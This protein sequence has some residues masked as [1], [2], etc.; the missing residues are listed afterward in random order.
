MTR[1]KNILV[2]EFGFASGKTRE[3]VL[4]KREHIEFCKTWLIENAEK[5]NVASDDCINSYGLKH[6]IESSVGAYITNGACIQAA[7]DLG[8]RYWRDEDSP[9]A[10]FFMAFK[11]VKED[12]PLKPTGFSKWLF[13][14]EDYGYLPDAEFDPEFPR[15]A[16]RFIDFW[17]YFEKF[18]DDVLEELCRAWKKYS[19]EEPPRPDLIDTRLVYDRECDFISLEEDYPKAPKGTKYL[20]ALVE[21]E[22]EEFGDDLEKQIIEFVCVKYIGQTDDPSGRLKAHVLRP[23][24]I[25][26]VKWIGGLL[27]SGKFP[28]M[29]IFQTVMNDEAHW[30]ERA[31]IYAFQEHETRLDRDSLEF[32]PID[33]ALLNI[34]K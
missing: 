33:N 21:I 20:Y 13:K 8:F 15:T 27:N 10:N 23:G 29:A 5:K 12:I 30:L 17:R 9:N 32:P 6:R 26:K 7:M 19:G 14:E 1:K 4:P 22:E 3:V 24:N 28:Q 34:H 2:G 25:D 11:G 31:A 16:T 18:G